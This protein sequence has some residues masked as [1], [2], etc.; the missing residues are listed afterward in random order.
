M[1]IKAAGTNIDSRINLIPTGTGGG[2]L[3][4]SAN[5]LELQVAGSFMAL[6]N[7]SGN[8]GLGTSTIRQRFHQHVGDGGANYH[9]FTNTET[10]TASTDGSVVGIDSDE[11]LLLWQQENLDVRIG[12]AGSDRIRVKNDGK[13]GIGTTAPAAKLHVEGVN[14]TRNTHTNTLVIDGGRTVAHPYPPFGFG[15]HFQGDD[16]SDEVR[17]YASIRTIMENSHT[18]TSDVGDPSFRSYLSF[19]TNSGG[20]D[21]TD[22]TEKLRI[23]GN[24][25][26]NTGTGSLSNSTYQLRVDADTDDGVYVSAGSSSSNHSFYVENAAGSKEYLAVRGDGEVRINASAQ[27]DCKIGT[28]AD[29]P[30][31]GGFVFD[32][33][34]DSILRIGH[35]SAVSD[36]SNYLLFY[37]STNIIGSITQSGT[38]ATAYNTSSDYRLKEDLKDFNGLDKVSKIP[39]YDFKWKPDDMRG[40][41]VMAHELQE[42]IPQAVVGKKD[43]EQMQGVDYSKLVPILLKSIQEQQTIIED[44]KK[45]IETLEK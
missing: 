23:T 34:T 31:G 7:S 30:S 28:T 43:G 2:V 32:N 26:L 39:V 14:A 11:N 36:G 42:I 45:R 44:L 6:I 8:L 33:A 4:A 17:N 9:A 12:S 1:Y 40:Y 37:H 35:A 16:Y 22:I 5:N 10:G 3:N 27:G 24:G 20:A 25:C 38:T 13:V 21:S 15:I 29:T 41:G 18:S 19:W